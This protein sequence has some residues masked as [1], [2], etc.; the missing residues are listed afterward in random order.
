MKTIS[1]DALY[2]YTKSQKVSSVY[3]KPF[4][5]S[6]DFLLRQAQ[7]TEIICKGKH[8]IQNLM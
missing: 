1:N 2:N 3:Y 5:Q 4:R 7:F 8:E 6:R